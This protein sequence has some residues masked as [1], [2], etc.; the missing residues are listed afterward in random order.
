V[1]DA[2]RGA[3]PL[4]AYHITAEDQHDSA[5]LRATVTGR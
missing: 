3:D 1:G 5:R 4:M 2:N